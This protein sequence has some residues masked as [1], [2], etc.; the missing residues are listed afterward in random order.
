MKATPY[1]KYKDIAMRNRNAFRMNVPSQYNVWYGDGPDELERHVFEL[2]PRPAHSKLNTK[3]VLT[4]NDLSLLNLIIEMPDTLT[5]DVT[6]SA[7]DWIRAGAKLLATSPEFP[8]V[9][10]VQEAFLLDVETYVTELENNN[11]RDYT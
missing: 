9:E 4:Y 5:D 11:I 3:F 10:C 8:F 1:E 6:L 2:E 7:G